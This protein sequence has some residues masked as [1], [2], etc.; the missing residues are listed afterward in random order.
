MGGWVGGRPEVKKW[1]CPN[2]D[3][4]LRAPFINFISLRRSIFLIWVLV[5]GWGGRGLAG[6]QIEG[7][8]GGDK[9]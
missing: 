1:A 6:P 7:G 4:K 2:V 9:Q 5:C 8:G 3:F